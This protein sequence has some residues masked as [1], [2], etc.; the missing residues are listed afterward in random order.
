MTEQQVLYKI[1]DAAYKVRDGL[2]QVL[3]VTKGRFSKEEIFTY[4]LLREIIFDADIVKYTT[5]VHTNFPNF[6]NSNK[7]ETDRTKMIGENFELSEVI[8]SC[9]RVIH[10]DN[11]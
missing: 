5:I 10:V 7:C 1:A 8:K 6:R 4:N 3:F 2:N 11:S 9:K